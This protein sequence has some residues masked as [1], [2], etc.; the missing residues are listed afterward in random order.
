[1]PTLSSRRNRIIWIILL[2]LSLLG[3]P[4]LS[5]ALTVQD[6]PNP[7]QQYGGWV[8]DMANILSERTETQLNQMISE[9]E[10]TTGAEIAV[11]TVPTTAPSPTA[12]DFTTELFN[13]WEIGKEGVDNGVLF[14]TSVGDR[15]V[16]IETGYGV[17]SI[18]PDAQVA[19]II[20]TEITPK[21]RGGDWEGGILAGTIALVTQLSVNPPVTEF[22]DSSLPTQFLGITSLIAVIFSFY[23]YQ[24]VKSRTNQPL[25]LEPQGRSLVI[26]EFD[27]RLT[28]GVSGWIYCAVFSLSFALILLTLIVD[29][30]GMLWRGFVIVS[31]GVG[32]LFLIVDIGQALYLYVTTK[33]LGNTQLVNSKVLAI[34]MTWGLLVLCSLLI[35][36]LGRDI[37]SGIRQILSLPLSSFTEVSGLFLFVWVLSS[38][39]VSYVISPRLIAAFWAKLPVKCQKCQTPLIKLNSESLSDRFTPPQQVAQRLGSTRFEGWHCPHC[40][41]DDSSRFHLRRYLLN[42]NRFSECPHCH[43]FTMIL[44]EEK[45]L[46]KATYERGGIRQIVY[47][48]QCCNYRE[49]NQ[50]KIPRLTRDSSSSYGGGYGGTYGG[51]GGGGGGFGGGSSGGGGAGGDF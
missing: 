41:P 6:V 15:R 28:T 8:S 9:L 51:G 26:S 1:M 7:R 10:A 42:P 47:E 33:V 22:S 39:L 24:K 25:S 5:H 36:P 35:I 40:Y 19:Q 34:L 12:K 13:T 46:R 17:E 27:N 16:E 49:D 20:N 37:S 44:V 18:L 2:C 32:S 45:T 50:K 21:L 3:F 4:L 14:L 30:S 23:S 48:C 43:E 11:V 38:S 31:L 29:P